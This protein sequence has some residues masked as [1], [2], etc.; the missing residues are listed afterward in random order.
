MLSAIQDCFKIKAKARLIMTTTNQ[1]LL[2]ELDKC[3]K[4]IQ[5]LKQISTYILESDVDKPYEFTYD[6]TCILLRLG[7]IMLHTECIKTKLD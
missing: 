6:M 7:L 1:L 2:Q 5:E 3:Q 4:W